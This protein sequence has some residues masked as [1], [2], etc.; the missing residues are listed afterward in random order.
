MC[1][2]SL[3]RWVDSRRIVGASTE[4]RQTLLATFAFSACNLERG[5]D[6]LAYFEVFHVRPQLVDLAH[7]LL[8]MV[9][10]S[11]IA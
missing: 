9:R 5:N 1:I 11:D 10:L 7:E 3:N 2:Y 8:G 6:A 4:R